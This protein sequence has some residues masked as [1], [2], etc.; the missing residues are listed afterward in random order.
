ML[1]APVGIRGG[2]IVPDPLFG[3]VAGAGVGVGAF[4]AQYLFLVGPGLQSLLESSVTTSHT[5][6]GAEHSL[7]P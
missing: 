3:V 2:A 5:A 4:I 1:A 7:I 6:P